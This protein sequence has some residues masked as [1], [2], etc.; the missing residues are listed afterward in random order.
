MLL[1]PI[2]LLTADA[3]RAAAQALVY[4][5]NPAAAD[6][7]FRTRPHVSDEALEARLDDLAVT[8]R[9]SSELVTEVEAALRARQ[10][11]A[12]KLRVEVETAQRIKNLTQE[13]RD[14]VAVLL[15]SEVAREGRKNLWQGVLVNAVFFCLGILAT[16]LI[17]T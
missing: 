5:L 4:A 9:R 13:E 11:A 12:E 8:M 7:I 15:R 10:A 6:A 2:A 14:A 3:A 17:G 1:E 16:L